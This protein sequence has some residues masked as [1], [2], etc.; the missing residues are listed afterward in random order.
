MQ[1]KCR[2]YNDLVWQN[3]SIA[4]VKPIIIKHYFRINYFLAI[5][6]SEQMAGK[7]SSVYLD[8]YINRIQSFISLSIVA[9]I[10]S[11]Q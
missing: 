1:K 3:D 4:R 9:L 6:F 11:N 7:P 2:N 8:Y 5:L 10:L